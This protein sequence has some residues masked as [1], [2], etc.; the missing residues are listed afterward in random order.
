MSKLQRLL[1]IVVVLV[2][3]LGSVGSVAIAEQGN[4]TGTDTQTGG[5][6]AGPTKPK[7]TPPPAPEPTQTPQQP[8][9]DNGGGGGGTTTPPK[10]SSG[11]SAQTGSQ[12]PNRPAPQPQEPPSN[13]GGGSGAV[14]VLVDLSEQRVWVYRGDTLLDTTLVRTGKAGFETPTGTWY[15]NSKYRYD[16]M[17]G[18]EG[19]E[20]WNV[21]NVPHAMYFTGNGHALHGAPWA[22]YWGRPASHG[23][24]NLPTGF[25]AWLFDIAP[26]G[27]KVVIR[28]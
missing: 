16:D 18:R 11:V 28:Y 19:G 21:S 3:L 24:V 14:S 26:V 25:A 20:A 15:I 4:Q 6:K 13:P 10:N 9:T 17:R 27:T 8:P 1:G 7:P 5:G 23:C 2:M 12:G 22:T